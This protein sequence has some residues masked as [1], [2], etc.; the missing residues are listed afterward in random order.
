M[1]KRRNRRALTFEN[2]GKTLQENILKPK[3]PRVG[4]IFLRFR[5]KIGHIKPRD[6]AGFIKEETLCG[7]ESKDKN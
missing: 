1:A 5:P 6:L 4:H 2:G 3:R 7:S